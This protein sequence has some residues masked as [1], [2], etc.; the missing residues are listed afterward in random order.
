MSPYPSSVEPR[1]PS[2]WVARWLLAI[3]GIALLAG[4]LG[5]AG[6]WARDR[7]LRD[8]ETQARVSAQLSLTA[9]NHTLDKFHA[10]PSILAQDTALAAKADRI[11][12]SRN[13]ELARH[14]AQG[15]APPVGAQPPCQLAAAS[16][17]R[18]AAAADF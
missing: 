8:L 13:P 6:A 5:G 18:P 16:P 7:A 11:L 12:A 2:A 14:R 3:A 10:I 1:H 4:V 17:E 9:L 15:A